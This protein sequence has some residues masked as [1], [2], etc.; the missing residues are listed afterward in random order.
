MVFEI[1]NR[2]RFCVYQSYF[3]CVSACVCAYVRVH[4]IIYCLPR[5]MYYNSKTCL[6]PSYQLNSSNSLC[7][8]KI[9]NMQN[10]QKFTNK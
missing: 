8:L 5:S 7:S 10:T 2:L 1:L 9:K 6:L 4:N 3:V